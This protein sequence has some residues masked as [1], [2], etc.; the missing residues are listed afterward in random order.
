MA[1]DRRQRQ[2]EHEAAKK[3]A[4]QK[5]ASRKE[6]TRRVLIALGMGALVVV[7]LLLTNLLGGAEEELPE[8]YA[9]LR[10]QPTA[11]D[12]EAPEPTTLERW[13]EPADQALDGATVLATVATSCGDFVIEVD[14]TL[15]P[16]SANAFVFLARQGA[17][18]GT[19]FTLVDPALDM[20]FGDPEG[21]G[22]GS[23]FQGYR[24]PDEFPA[25][26]FEM[27]RGVVAL[28]GD[29][30]SRGTGLFVVVADDTPLSSRFNVL[31]RV[32]EGLETLDRIAE[33][34][35]KAP[36]GS[37]ART[38]PAETVYVESVTIADS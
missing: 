27:D 9:A 28:T 4:A 2:K 12:A 22:T 29:R 36:P 13:G 20:E 7:L 33:V 23:H 32:V 35:R 17:Y 16:E 25:D 38:L 8:A 5:A 1:N 18:D 19:T 37:A 14:S 30:S 6:L 21:D 26:G 3:A 11:C 34:D 31:G 15:A 24:L 10:E